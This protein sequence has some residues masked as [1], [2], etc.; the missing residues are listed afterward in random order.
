MYD[1]DGS[2]YMQCKNENNHAVTVTITATENFCIGLKNA[3]EKTLGISCHIYDA[4]CHNGITRVFTLSG[5]NV[6]K[7][8]LD[9]IYENPIIYM[10]RK[11]DRYLE[12][13]NI[14]NSL[15]V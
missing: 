8:F 13:Y 4:S 14:N 7:I 15:A 3:V 9:W 1:G 2:V 11:Y 5:R 6:A 12:Y 10:Q